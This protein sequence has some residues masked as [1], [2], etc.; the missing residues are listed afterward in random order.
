MIRVSRSPN[1]HNYQVTV[2][3]LIDPHKA[4]CFVIGLVK[5]GVVRTLPPTI[6]T[7][8]SF[9][10]QPPFAFAPISTNLPAIPGTVNKWA[11]QHRRT[12]GRSNRAQIPLRPAQNMPRQGRGLTHSQVMR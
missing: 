12:A 4:R 5:A 7:L 1:R 10:L 3:R 2:L 11:L 9:K 6:L 8:E